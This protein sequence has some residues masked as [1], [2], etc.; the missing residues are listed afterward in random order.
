MIWECLTEIG[1]YFAVDL[2]CLTGARNYFTM[3]WECFTEA[4]DFFYYSGLGMF[5]RDWKL[6]DNDFEMFDN[7]CELCLSGLGLF[8]NFANICEWL[9]TTLQFWEC[10]T[11]AVNCLTMAEN[12]LAVFGTFDSG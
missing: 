4:K 11:M 7:G 9:G 10:S 2:E 3:I 8:H 5:N 1:Y 6:L 12:Y